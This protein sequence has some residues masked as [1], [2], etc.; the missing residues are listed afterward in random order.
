MTAPDG[1]SGATREEDVARGRGAHR[2]RVVVGLVGT[3]LVRRDVPAVL[4]TSVALAFLG[5]VLSTSL[6]T[7]QLS[8]GHATLTFSAAAGALAGACL[9]GLLRGADPVAEVRSPRRLPHLRRATAGAVAAITVLVLAGAGGAGWDLPAVRSYLLTAATTTVLWRYAGP[10]AAAVW[11]AA[12]AG[13]CLFV[14]AGVDGSARWWA[15]PLQATAQW[16]WDTTTLLLAALVA[17]LVSFR[18]AC[19]TPR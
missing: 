12:Y 3:W 6:A 17:I 2:S 16:S 5:R 1:H 15:V 11:F 19:T 14:G 10:Y 4:V 18:S 13:A 7:P 8:G 9:G